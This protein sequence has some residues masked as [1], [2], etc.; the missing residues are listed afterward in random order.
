VNLTTDD[1]I[2]GCITTRD[3]RKYDSGLIQLA[4]FN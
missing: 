4:I 1:Y 3:L 2:F